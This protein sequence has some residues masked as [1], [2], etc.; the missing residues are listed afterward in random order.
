[1]PPR[2]KR[3]D[4]ETDYRAPSSLLPSKRA[5]R[6]QQFVQTSSAPASPRV[7]P[8]PELDNG[9][10]EQTLPTL[11]PLPSF[12]SKLLDPTK[13]VE[14]MNLDGDSLQT[15]PMTPRIQKQRAAS[16]VPTLVPSPATST[17]FEPSPVKLKGGRSRAT[18]T[19]R[20]PRN[21]KAGM[22]SA[23]KE[24]MQA[25]VLKLRRAREAQQ[26]RELRAEVAEVRRQEFEAAIEAKEERDHLRAQQHFAKIT[27][28]VE[29]GG[30]G[31]EDLSTFFDSLFASGRGGD[32][33]MSANL[34]R[35]LKTH[36]E[37]VLQLIVERVPEVGQQFLDKELDK[38]LEEVLKAEG[39]A[40]QSHLT[41][42]WTTSITE[43]LKEFSMEKLGEELQEVAPTLWRILQQV[44][45][46]DKETRRESAGT[47]RREK[48]LVFT[49]VC[50]MLSM[51]RSQK[52]NNYQVVIGMFLLA[53]GSAKREI[54]VLAHAGLSV[55]YSTIQN[56]IHMLSSEA[57][58]R[59]K[60]LAKEKMIF[61]VWDNLNIAFRPPRTTTF[62]VIDWTPEDVLPSPTQL[63]QLNSCCLW[64]IKRLA[65]EN[66]SE[67]AHLKELL[68]DCPEVDP[69]A[70][71]KTEQY[72]LPAM[73][74]DES[75][76][77]GTARVYE[78]ILANLGLSN[79]DIRA[80]GLIFNDGD[81][82]TDSLVDKIES[83]RR[84]SDGEIQGMKASIR[85][86][87]LF[88]AKMA[89][90]SLWWEHTRLLKRKPMT[91]G[92]KAKKATPWKPSHELLQISLA[93][94]VK[95]VFIYPFC[96]YTILCI[97]QCLF[98][99]FWTRCVFR[100]QGHKICECIQWVLNDPHGECDILLIVR[101]GN[102]GTV[103]WKLE[104]LPDVGDHVF[105][106]GGGGSQYWYTA[107]N[108]G[109]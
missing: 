41:R 90:C 54:E 35:F 27:A 97:E 17:I 69:I 100:K 81:L 98:K 11:Q 57:L 101:D 51:S 26:K 65:L 103:C 8:E 59:L 108:A 56:H 84:N 60:E 73:H 87:G 77:D 32:A 49:T 52:A 93:A 85:R 24:Q 43:L 62:P 107:G 79:E 18:K 47:S 4:S 12:I 50:A 39:E 72:P 40:I 25:D 30:A 104:L 71:H 75:S 37:H 55:S 53:S 22:S 66:I 29:D 44:S 68:K 16:E 64:Q 70:V 6:E 102:M 5:R 10:L 92:W 91:A 106:H 20:N 78:K 88:H 89:G 9:L 13:T 21:S 15:S 33:Q 82:L 99:I 38:K 28:P 1:M 46:P 19:T 67:L 7:S 94:H 58:R 31:F 23:E 45:T 86:F 48:S 83:A 14:S 109:Q 80:H 61:I 63:S 2:R 76:I 42:E 105:R 74:E 3:R 34:T 96:C 95:D 36:G